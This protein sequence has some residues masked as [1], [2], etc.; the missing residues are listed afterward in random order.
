MTA[1]TCETCKSWAGNQASYLAVCRKTKIR[2]PFDGT[3]SAWAAI[4][5]PK[6]VVPGGSTSVQFVPPTLPK[7]KLPRPGIGQVLDDLAQDQ[8][9]GSNQQPARWEPP[10]GALLLDSFS[11]R[12]SIAGEPESLRGTLKMSAADFV[13]RQLLTGCRVRCWSRAD[14]TMTVEA[15]CVVTR[16]ECNGATAELWVESEGP[17]KLM[18]R[19]A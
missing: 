7:K 12:I 1:K 4:N 16:A 17:V 9:A 18:M 5:E 6:Q 8:Q 14:G 11:L 15:L 13:R 10:L 2:M 19:G 3:C